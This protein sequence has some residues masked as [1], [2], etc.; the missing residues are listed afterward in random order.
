MRNMRRGV[1]RARKTREWFWIEKKGERYFSS[2]WITCA[3]A[4]R[5]IQ[6]KKPVPKTCVE[7]DD[8]NCFEP[9]P[10]GTIEQMTKAIDKL[11]QDSAE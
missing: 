1:W 10:D 9:V 6:G 2:Y 7:L 4:V 3:D 8:I 5:I 11:W